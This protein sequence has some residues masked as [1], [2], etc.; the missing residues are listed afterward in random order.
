MFREIRTTV[1]TIWRSDLLLME[2]TAN[3]VG[4]KK[5]AQI[6][7]I[8]AAEVQVQV[9][10]VSR[11]TK[12]RTALAARTIC[13]VLFTSS[14]RT[15][16]FHSGPATGRELVLVGTGTVATLLTG[17]SITGCAVSYTTGLTDTAGV[18]F[19]RFEVDFG[20][21]VEFAGTGVLPAAAALLETVVGAGALVALR[22]PFRHIRQEGIGQRLALGRLADHRLRFR[23]FGR[24]QGLARSHTERI[25]LVQRC[26]PSLV[27]R[28]LQY[29]SSSSSSS[30]SSNGSYE[31]CLKLFAG[32]GGSSSS[33]M[34]YSACFTS[35]GRCGFCWMSVRS[36]SGF[37][38]LNETFRMLTVR[39][40]PFLSGAAAAA[41]AAGPP[42]SMPSS[43]SSPLASSMRGGGPNIV[44][45][46][47]GCGPKSV[48]SI[49]A[50][51]R[52]GWNRFTKVS[53]SI[54]TISELQ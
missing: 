25:D 46:S 38:S 39:L 42:S 4:E 10:S 32:L 51:Y 11:A 33:A 30:S 16:L 12:P 8:W 21:G 49:H 47:S 13:E 14:G 5:I 24:W 29:S 20:F 23:R 40:Q 43:R 31:D 48:P 45:G 44:V 36:R 54:F 28:C 26:G 6:A 27:G 50:S 7:L 2:T 52:S 53:I 22:V 34:P 41:A 17:L 1:E 18:D 3:T 19:R 35:S 37:F 9:I 15:L